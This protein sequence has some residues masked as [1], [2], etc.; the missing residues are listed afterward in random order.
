LGNIAFDAHIDGAIDSLELT[1]CIAEANIRNFDYLGYTY[2]NIHL[3]GE[4]NINEING[5]LSI[6]DDNLKLNIK[7]L[8]DWDQNDTRFDLNVRFE[9]F[10]PA[11][12]HLTQKN[13]DLCIGANTYISLYTSGTPKEMLDNLNG[14]II[15]DSLNLVNGELANTIEQFK[16]LIDSETKEGLPYHQ[17][18]VQSDLVTGNLSGTFTYEALPSISQ[19]L[20]HKYLPIL[21]DKPSGEYPANTNFDF[22][23]YLES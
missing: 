3:D 2:N 19:H 4:W 5:T 11:A 17:F 22:Y 23:A 7:G 1:H 15:I 12:L 6:N 20:L 18:R 8:A 10:T 14:Y 13:P 16:V 21:I 9:D